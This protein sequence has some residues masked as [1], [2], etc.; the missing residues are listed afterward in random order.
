M[1]IT[2]LVSLLT[3]GLGTTF[4]TTTDALQISA[5]G[6]VATIQDN[7]VSCAGTGCL[8]LSGDESGAPGTVTVGGT[9]GDW[10][11][12]V[13]SGLSNSPTDVPVGLSLTVIASCAVG[14]G[15]DST[16]LDVQFSDINFSP[17]N[18][19]FFDGYSVTNLTAGN[20]SQSAYYSN[21]NALFVET[22]GGLI[23]TLGPF[24]GTTTGSPEVTGGTGSSAPYSL[25]LDEVFNAGI[26]T[27]ALSL[28]A[29]GSI[30]SNVPEPMSLLLLGGCL[31]FVGRKL[32]A[33]LA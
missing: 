30:D 25:T 26:G 3:I 6:L 28:N 14:G 15:C 8:F 22:L 1:K 11:I 27:A 23:G 9:I 4:G 2:L 20:T 12:S 13:V 21:A 10:S 29:G 32:T 31:L 33:R 7:V 24:S 16:P 18:P 5:A 19:S 17:A